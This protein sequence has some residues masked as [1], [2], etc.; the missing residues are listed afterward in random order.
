MAGSVHPAIESGGDNNM[1]LQHEY[2][3]SQLSSTIDMH[4]RVKWEFEDAVSRYLP[5][6]YKRAHRFV[7]NQ[8]DAEDVV[9]DA[10]LSAYKH[11]DKFN[12][13]AKM[14]TW[15]TSIVIN[16]ALTQLR[17]RPRQLHISLDER[18]GEDRDY[19]VLDRLADARSNPENDYIGSEM[20]RHILRFVTELS[21]ALRKAIQ[22]RVFDG[23]TK[24]EAADTLGVS[25]STLKTQVSQARSK[26]K[27]KI[28]E[29]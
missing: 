3:G 8:H 19:S 13:T 7:G 18:P 12:G 28:R 2:T 20:H 14:T 15:L 21:P 27:Q 16:S 17:R 6:L 5:A 23:L 1:Q 10:L 24:N 26:M 4:E 25:G 9:Q 22:L 11:L 29:L